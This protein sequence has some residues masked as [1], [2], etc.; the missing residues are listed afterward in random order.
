MFVKIKLTEPRLRS[1]SLCSVNLIKHTAHSLSSSSHIRESSL[2]ILFSFVLFNFNGTK[3][4][5]EARIKQAKEKEKH[6]EPKELN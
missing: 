5:S 2:F 1:T 4:V 6:K 3:G